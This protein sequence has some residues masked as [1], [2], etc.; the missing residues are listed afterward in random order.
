MAEFEVDGLD[1]RLM[2]LEPSNLH[3][4]LSL[5]ALD[6]IIGALRWC[7]QVGASDRSMEGDEH[8]CRT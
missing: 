4:T 6:G 8:Q 5:I 3:S 1:E 7:E 2:K